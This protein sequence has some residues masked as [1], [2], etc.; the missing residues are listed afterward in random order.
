[1]NTRSQAD[2][3]CEA[4]RRTILRL[5]QITNRTMAQADALAAAWATLR[6]HGRR[7]TR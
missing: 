1:M 7:M 3:E 5:E 4:A 2:R 6:K